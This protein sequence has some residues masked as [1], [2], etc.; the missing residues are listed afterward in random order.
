MHINYNQLCV[1]LH[2]ILS[3]EI[4]VLLR[5]FSV[6]AG[7]LK[8]MRLYCTVVPTMYLDLNH[9]WLVQNVQCF[10]SF[11]VCTQFLSSSNIQCLVH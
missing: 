4:P 1:H 8:R 5:K 3:V 6:L 9:M 10:V 11:T 7:C 2:N